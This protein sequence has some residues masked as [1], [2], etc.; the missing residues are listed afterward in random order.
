SSHTDWGNQYQKL[1]KKKEKIM[2]GLVQ[3][4]RDAI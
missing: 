4:K 1:H 2:V 3:W